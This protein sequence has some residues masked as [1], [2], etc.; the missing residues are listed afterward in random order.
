M[1]QSALILYFVNQLSSSDERQALH[2]IMKDLVALQMTRRQ[3]LLPY[4]NGKPKT[5]AQANRQVQRQRI[6]TCI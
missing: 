6:T 1:I 5:P 4:D 3:P 2:S